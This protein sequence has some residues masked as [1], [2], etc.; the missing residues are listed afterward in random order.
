MDVILGYIGM[1]TRMYTLKYSVKNAIYVQTYLTIV[2]NL[3]FPQQ[4][5][6]QLVILKPHIIAKNPGIDNPNQR[7]LIH[8]NICKVQS[9]KFKRSMKYC[10]ILLRSIMARFMVLNLILLE[11]IIIYN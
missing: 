9:E 5:Q 3:L 7:C 11:Q 1:L 10:L 8:L 2:I 4:H 6:Q